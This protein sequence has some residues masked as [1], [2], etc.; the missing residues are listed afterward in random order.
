MASCYHKKSF[1]ELSPL[2]RVNID[3]GIAISNSSTKGIFVQLDNGRWTQ[4]FKCPYSDRKFRKSDVCS[5]AKVPKAKCTV[6]DRQELSFHGIW[7][8][9]QTVIIIGLDLTLK[10]IGTHTSA[11]WSGIFFGWL[12]GRSM[13]PEESF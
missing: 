8:T 6:M 11:P 9:L 12:K 2:L 10:S 3:N 7:H 4:K 1:L 5:C 13:Q